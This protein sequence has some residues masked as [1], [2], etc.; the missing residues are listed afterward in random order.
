MACLLGAAHMRMGLALLGAC[1]G[2]G[3]EAREE[4]R[5][6]RPGELQLEE[7]GSGHG[8]F[9]TSR[10]WYTGGTSYLKAIKRRRMGTITSTVIET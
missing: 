9:E 1:M 7:H 6:S 10:R 8:A 5:K 4:V 2:V 3:E